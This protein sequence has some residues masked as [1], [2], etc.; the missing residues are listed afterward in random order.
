MSRAGSITL[1]LTPKGDDLRQYLDT[2]VEEIK[3]ITGVD[4]NVTKYIQGL[5][6]ADREK[7][8]NKDTDESKKHIIIDLL[9]T[10][11]A[12]RLDTIYHVAL[13]I[14]DVYALQKTK[15]ERNQ[16][17]LDK[18][19]KSYDELANGDVIIKSMTELRAME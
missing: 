14:S 18:L 10:L 7:R 1:D 6:K 5:I 12:Q 11:D 15:E 3:G 2:R 4:T 19:D 9:D 13:D 16:A 8:I 17:Y